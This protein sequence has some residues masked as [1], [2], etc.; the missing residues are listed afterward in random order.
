MTITEYKSENSRLLLISNEPVEIGSY[1]Q[2][3]FQ[4]VSAFNSIIFTETNETQGIVKF[5]DA[6]GSV[7]SEVSITSGNAIIN[8]GYDYIKVKIDNTQE[9]MAYFNGKI[10]FTKDGE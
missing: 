3:Q 2:Y 6:N 9:G 5:L 8:P 4:S 10:L 1:L 7:A